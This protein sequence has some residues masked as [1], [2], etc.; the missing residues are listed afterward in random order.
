MLSDREAR[1]VLAVAFADRGIAAP[2]LP[3]LQG[4]QAV[5]RLEGTY[6]AA[7]GGANNWGAIQTHDKVPCV[8][9]QSTEITDHDAWGK[10]YQVCVRCYPSPE[11]GAADLVRELYR[12]PNV[13]DALRAGNADALA[14]AMHQS[15]YFAQRNVGAYAG[16]ISWGAQRIATHIGEPWVV[17]RAV[18]LPASPPP[19]SSGG[20]TGIVVAAVAVVGLGIAARA[21]VAQRA[22]RARA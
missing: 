11:A 13:P 20:G 9:G 5:G 21:R 12:R 7:F 14:E 2:S 3:E 17:R 15:G 10:P 6:G 16:W 1:R 18:D 19:P 8:P 22:G 4:V